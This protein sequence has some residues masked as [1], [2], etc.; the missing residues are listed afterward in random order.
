MK[1]ENQWL[2]AMELLTKHF[3]GD[4]DKATLWMNT[5]NPLLGDQI[6]TVMI[7]IGRG[8]KLLKFMKVQLAENDKVGDTHE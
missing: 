8:K 7:S 2:E 5:K 4:A 3:S 1:Y 6:P